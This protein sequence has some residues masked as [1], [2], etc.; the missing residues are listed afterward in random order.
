MCANPNLNH[1]F[2]NCVLSAKIAVKLHLKL[3]NLEINSAASL[4]GPII[5][6]PLPHLAVLTGVSP[7]L[8][9]FS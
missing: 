9:E 7:I 5:S 4:V 1:I 3:I 6:A 2:I 8:E